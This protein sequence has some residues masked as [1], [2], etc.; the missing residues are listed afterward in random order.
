MNWFTGF[1]PE[2]TVMIIVA[3]IAGIFGLITI[4]VQFIWPKK[5]DNQEKAV[6][7]ADS[8]EKISN[9][10]DA[11]LNRVKS[12][13]KEA[14]DR[15]AANQKKIKDMEFQIQ[16]VRL[17]ASSENQD[18]RIALSELRLNFEKERAVRINVERE[19]L[20]LRKRIEILDPKPAGLKI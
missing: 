9:A 11:I 20:D 8:A 18:L 3:Y 10:Y 16:Q 12:E 7:T 2:E 4:I 14:L 1:T 19:N 6:D 17:D 15:D 13:L 5:R